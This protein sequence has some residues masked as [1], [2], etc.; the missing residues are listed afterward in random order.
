MVYNRVPLFTIVYKSRE[1][2]NVV[3]FNK[4]A[5]VLAFGSPLSSNPMMW[6][7]FG[8]SAM[9]ML[10]E[11]YEKGHIS[12]VKSFRVTSSDI[13]INR[14]KIFQAAADA[15]VDYLFMVDNDMVIPKDA[16]E[17]FLELEKVMPDC[18]LTGHAAVG[19]PPH[20]P[21]AWM[22]DSAGEGAILWN[23]P[24]R[25]FECHFVGGFG[26]WIP[27]S[28]LKSRNLVRDPF[29]VMEGDK[30]EDFAFCRNVRDAGHKIIVDPNIEF[31]HLRPQKI[32][33]RHWEIARQDLDESKYVHL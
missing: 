28:I 30:A 5:P 21:A 18:L 32:S 25:P 6:N 4:K 13:A 20:Y 1:V 22:E 16:V 3:M 10:C 7:D 23:V 11:A 27:K 19:G 33:K 26:L 9:D 24:D 15:N 17:R 31:G 29:T 12:A 2:Y 14:N 8:F